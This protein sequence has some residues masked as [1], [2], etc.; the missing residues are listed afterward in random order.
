MENIQKL[1]DIIDDHEKRIVAL[2]GLGAKDVSMGNATPV[3]KKVSL[4]EFLLSKKPSNDVQRTLA[5]GYYLEKFEGMT[6]FN[7]GE[8]EGSFVSA[9]EKA[10]ENINDKVNMNIRKG[11]IMELKEKKNNKKAWCLT[12]T[13]EILVENNF[14]K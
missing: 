3:N 6:S 1:I 2:E 9:K 10:P 4:K 5:I 11:H 13:G 8:L 14:Q 12:S 7:F